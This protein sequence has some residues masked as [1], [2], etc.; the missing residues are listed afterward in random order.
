[1]WVG[2]LATA[3]GLAACT[4]V[5]DDP[6]PAA[7]VPTLPCAEYESARS[8]AGDARCR[9]LEPGCGSGWDRPLESRG[10]Y[11]RDD[12]DRDDCAAGLTCREVVVNPCPAHAELEAVSCLAC[13]AE[14]RVCMP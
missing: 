6:A 7:N 4:R 5:A 9:W 13:G 2:C 11:L 12:C 3:L 14:A 1:M 8:C 10:C